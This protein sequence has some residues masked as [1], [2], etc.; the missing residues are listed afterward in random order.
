MGFGLVGGLTVQVALVWSFTLKH[1]FMVSGSLEL[2]A[3]LFK[4]SVGKIGSEDFHN[5]LDRPQ[6]PSK[7]MISS[8]GVVAALLTVARMEDARGHL[9]M[10]LR[11]FLLRFVHYCRGLW[12]FRVYLEGTLYLSISLLMSG[13]YADTFPEMILQHASLSWQILCV[14]DGHSIEQEEGYETHSLDFTS[15]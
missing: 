1:L 8:M 15:V 4:H 3:L 6:K 12:N 14:V 9:C 7:D 5:K 11:A 10:F 2:A 13:H